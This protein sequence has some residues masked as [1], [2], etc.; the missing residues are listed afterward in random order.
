VSESSSSESTR[1]PPEHE[2][3]LCRLLGYREDDIND[4]E[5]IATIAREG[6]GTKAIHCC[7]RCADELFETHDWTEYAELDGL[8]TAGDGDV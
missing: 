6:G 3:Q 8:D 2:C 1:F 5:G 7:K 4:R